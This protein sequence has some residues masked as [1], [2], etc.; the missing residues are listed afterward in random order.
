MTLLL[1]TESF[2]LNECKPL[3]QIA[4]GKQF[5]THNAKLWMVND[6]PGK[7]C[8]A[9]EVQLPRDAHLPAYDIPL[10]NCY[11]LHQFSVMLMPKPVSKMR[12]ILTRKAGSVQ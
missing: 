10:S 7:Y 11:T 6:K 4:E 9:R 8:L 3:M 2:P 12:K 5:V 1:I